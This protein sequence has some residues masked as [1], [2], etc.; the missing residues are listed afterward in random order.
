MKSFFID[1][2]VRNGFGPRLRP[3]ILPVLILLTSLWTNFAFPQS[4]PD[5]F[6]FEIKPPAG[7]P[8]LANPSC[9]F[10]DSHHGE[11]YVADTG[12]DRVVI[13]DRDGNY[14]FEFSE[15]QHLPSP[16]CLATDSTGR[17]LALC[18]RQPDRIVVLDYDG[19]YLRDWPLKDARTDS[20]VRATSFAVG[21]GDTVYV[22]AE[23][24]PRLFGYTTEGTRLWEADI[25]TDL[26]PDERM[27]QALGN[28]AC[29]AGRLIVPTPMYS[30]LTVFDTHGRFVKVFGYAGGAPGKLSFP[31]AAASDGQGGT[32][33]LDKHRH[34]V[35]QYGP[36]DI[37]V[38]EFGG[39]GTGAG[40]FYHPISLASDESSRCFVL[41][42]F[43]GRV[44]AA[45]I[46]GAH[47]TPGTQI[48]AAKPQGGLSVGTQDNK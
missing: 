39:M 20:S 8:A 27:Q 16:R 13:F 22:A 4:A 21:R 9:V 3:A 2:P 42:S 29:F 12:N 10:Y 47:E 5:Y 19:R 1:P 26:P 34:T 32:L 33:V 41:Q 44:Q 6:L 23:E 36:D 28:I 37:F 40:W 24:P 46:P 38:Q 18:E 43:M 25:L 14:V 15:R 31:I 30:N 11:I 17:I 35:L 45:K 7:V 48:S